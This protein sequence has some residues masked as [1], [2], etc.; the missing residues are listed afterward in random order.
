MPMLKPTKL[1]VNLLVCRCDAETYK[2]WFSTQLTSQSMLTGDDTW[3]STPLLNLL[4]MLETLI[5]TELA[6]EHWL[7]PVICSSIKILGFNACIPFKIKPHVATTY[8]RPKPIVF[9]MRW[10]QLHRTLTVR[11]SCDVQAHS[12]HYSLYRWCSG[13]IRTD[14]DS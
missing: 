12:Q 4:P 6:H 3:F 2:P 11:K 9:N 10:W 13:S 8:A 1:A 5:F 7:A 14:L